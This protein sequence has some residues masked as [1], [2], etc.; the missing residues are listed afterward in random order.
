MVPS[1][2]VYCTYVPVGTYSHVETCARALAV[3]EV[4]YMYVLAQYCT[5]YCTCSRNRTKNL[6][7]FPFCF[8]FSFDSWQ[9]DQ[10]KG[11]RQ[12]RVLLIPTL[13]KTTLQ[14]ANTHEHQNIPFRYNIITVTAN[15]TNN[16][17]TRTAT[18]F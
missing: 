8:L 12:S 9:F 10:K 1:L 7:C 14:H 3:V 13:D 15:K 18:R 17:N 5:Y 11:K 4:P 6:A 2:V 16:K